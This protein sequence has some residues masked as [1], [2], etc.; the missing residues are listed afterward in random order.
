MS[1]KCAILARLKLNTI[2]KL[3]TLLLGCFLWTK[4]G[5]I[6]I[7]AVSA[8]SLSCK[9]LMMAKTFTFSGG[10]FLNFTCWENQIRELWFSQVVIRHQSCGFP[11]WLYDISAGVFPCGYT[12]SMLE[13]FLWA[14]CQKLDTRNCPVQGA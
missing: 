1:C 6:V 12:T 13:R 14:Q 8:M 2:S 11:M 3:E 4:S 10:H 7:K 5:G 9:V